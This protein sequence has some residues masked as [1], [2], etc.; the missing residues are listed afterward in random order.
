MDNFLRLHTI[1]LS[2]SRW[3]VIARIYREASAHWRI[4][5]WATKAIFFGLATYWFFT[6]SWYPLFMATIAAAGIWAY[7]FH[8]A[9]SEV[10]AGLHQTYPEQL[11][12]FRK[13]YQYIRYLTFKERL[14]SSS[15][16]G[17]ARDALAFVNSQID[18]NPRSPITSHPFFTFTLGVFLAVIGGA[19]GQW[20]EEY[21]V[22]AIT[23]LVVILYFSYMILELARTPSSDLVEFR[24]FLL[25]ASNERP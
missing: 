24:Q 6:S 10:F 14:E 12:Y 2:A 19:A 21:V 7:S 16:I 9:R 20:A 1:Y 22:G 5:M 8:K 4:M 25:W 11:R 18:V 13:D 3:E 17:G 23:I 15:L